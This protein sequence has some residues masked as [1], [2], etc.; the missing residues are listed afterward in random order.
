MKQDIPLT[1]NEKYIFS[2]RSLYESYG[3]TLYKMSKFEEYDLYSKNKDFLVSDGVIT[4]TD[5]SGKLLALKPDVTLSIIKN[6]A[7]SHSSVQKLHYN[8][9]VYRVSKN[10]HEFREL[11]QVGLECIGDIDDMCLYEVLEL[12]SKS[13]KC[14]S[15]HCV[16]DVS[17]IGILLKLLDYTGIPEDE[18]KDAL[19]CIG[20]KNMHELASKCRALG[21]E[22]AKTDK[23]IGIIK[24]HGS[25]RITVEKIRRETAGIIDTS[26]TEEFFEIVSA[27]EN[28]GNNVNI[29]FSLV[30]D[31]N[32]YNGLIFKGFIEGI[33]NSVLSGGQYDTLMKKMKRTE[34]A[35]GFA[36]YL[37][38]LEQLN[39]N[40]E[41]FDADTIMV[42]NDKLA[43]TE[44]EAAAD[45]LRQ[46]GKSVFVTKEIP[47]GIR[48]RT[49][50]DLRNGEV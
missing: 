17:D 48:Y 30:E 28:S 50:I 37:D 11:M 29:D 49:V 18:K 14:I 46:D 5:T 16:L 35:V 32:Y 20:E 45:K 42:Y 15:E 47:Q 21:I 6:T 41:K 40:E 43:F 36:V 39:K 9:N 1:A 44:I 38:M 26:Q 31:I 27:L 24:L 22:D 10:T 12:S 19:R 23:L 34:R 3:Y 25:P 4:F 8:E 13:L 2:L 33:P 7:G